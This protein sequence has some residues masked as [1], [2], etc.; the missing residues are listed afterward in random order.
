M[1]NFVLSVHHPIF[2]IITWISLPKVNTH[3]LTFSDSI[4][5]AAVSDL[6]WETVRDSAADQKVMDVQVDSSSLPL[7]TSAEGEQVL[8]FYW[9]DAYEDQYRQPG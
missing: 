1:Y 6:G 9:L 4:N 3:S 2:G 8:R 5:P 7:T